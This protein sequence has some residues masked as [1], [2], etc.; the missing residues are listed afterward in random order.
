MK[1][2]TRPLSDLVKRS[3]QLWQSAIHQ[4]NLD[5]MPQP[6][7]SVL[8]MG[9]VAKVDGW[10]ISSPTI[11]DAISGIVERA[12]TASSFAVFTL[13]MDHLVRLR[14]D[15]A[16][17]R[18]YRS[19][20]I[21]TA[22]GAPIVWLARRHGARLARATGADMVLPLAQEAATH[23]IPIYLF[24]SSAASIAAA[25][26]ILSDSTGGLLD[27]AGSE[28]PPPDFDPTGREADDAIRRIARSGARI[29][30]IALGSPAQE[31][32]AARAVAHGLNCGFVCVG[33]GLEFIARRQRRAPKFM[34]R[35]GTEWL[36]LLAAD[37]LRLA[38]RYVDCAL[39]LADLAVVSPLRRRIEARL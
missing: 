36:W 17:R 27:I 11:A 8:Q 25:G 34:Q 3:R 23:K 33:A 31:L 7:V 15:A 1:K 24:G 21:V 4:L 35:T 10:S 38:P 14:R 26:R 39:R 16:F 6:S 13:N 20:A 29:A 18:A 9:A 28:A 2:V 12:A 19:A 5:V 37:P 32:F 22:A 30:L